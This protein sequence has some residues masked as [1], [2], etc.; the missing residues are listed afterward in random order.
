[1]PT[2]FIAFYL[3][4][5]HQTDENDLFWGE[6]FTE[7]TLVN[8]AK[9]KFPGHKQP[10]KS[11]TL[12]DYDLIN[13]TVRK[14]QA[15]LAREHGVD[16]FCYWHYYFGDGKSVL[17]KP[18]KRMLEDGEPNIPFLLAWANKSWT[19]NWRA[20]PDEVLIE[21]KYSGKD[22]IQR[23]FEEIFPYVASGR[24][25]EFDGKI[26]FLILYPQSVPKLSK[27]K[28]DWNLKLKERTGKE[29]VFMGYHR[30]DI[31]E[32]DAAIDF[33]LEHDFLFGKMDNRLRYFLFDKLKLPFPVNY[34]SILRRFEKLKHDEHSFPV[35]YTDWDNSPRLKKGSFIFR[36]FTPKTFEKFLHTASQLNPKRSENWVFIKSWNEWAEGNCLE[37]DNVHGDELL[38]SVLRVSTKVKTQ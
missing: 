7:W 15:E 9:S 37:P 31:R 32:D 34:N 36:N 18:L 3:P 11:T 24:Y 14:Q 25:L 12:G 4:Q 1:M 2:R 6:G 16:A 13:T 28:E 10:R 20:Q 38:Q 22:D 21:Q 17:D 30:Y 23:H 33:W 35:V 8:T 19:A 27:M 26:P 5:F 29:F